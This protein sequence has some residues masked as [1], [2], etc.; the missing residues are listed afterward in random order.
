MSISCNVPNDG[1]A[2]TVNSTLSKVVLRLVVFVRVVEHSLGRDAADVE[3]CA[4]ERSTLLNA[5]RLQMKA[6]ASGE[7]HAR[8]PRYT[9]AETVLGGLDGS[10]VATGA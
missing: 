7:E 8:R 1:G 3:T 10:Y 4:A 6:H 9:Y 5:C 2:L